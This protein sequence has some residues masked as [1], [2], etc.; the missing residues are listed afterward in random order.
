MSM[1]KD[2][3]R[4]LLQIG[5]V[6][7][8][9]QEP[10]DLSGGWKSPIYCD[11]RI[12]LSFVEEREFF[13]DNLIL[14][15]KDEC[16]LADAVCGVAT[17]G[18]SM[19]AIMADHLRLPYAYV[20][21]P[22]DHGMKNKIEGSLKPGSHVV[23]YDDVSTTGASAIKAFKTLRE[24]GYTVIGFITMLNYNFVGAKNFF[25]VWDIPVCSIT[26]LDV[27]CEVAGEMHQ[28]RPYE[29]EIIKQF[30]K[31]PENW[32]HLYWAP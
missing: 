25:T 16:P 17:G 14:R 12:G 13:R 4:R 30:S 5:A 24:A 18:I 28:L 20:R 11:N 31:D 8:N 26:N 32:Y 27:L 29:I 23:I 10:F 22:K 21:E 1:F 19:G 6:K 15:L 3:A 2:V 9:L 7:F